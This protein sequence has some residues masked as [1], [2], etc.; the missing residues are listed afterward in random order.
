MRRL[1]FIAVS[2]VVSVVILVLAVGNVPLADIGQR[3]ANV[4]FFWIAVC[5]L[6]VVLGM[7]GALLLERIAARRHLFRA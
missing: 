2:I 1:L 7:A 5:L 3:I 6:M 4:D